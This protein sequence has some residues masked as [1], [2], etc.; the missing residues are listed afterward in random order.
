MRD[1]LSTLAVTALLM[2]VLGGAL[3][4]VTLLMQWAMW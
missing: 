2:V 1:I 3:F 4:L